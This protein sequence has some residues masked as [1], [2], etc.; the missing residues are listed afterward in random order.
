MLWGTTPAFLEKLGIDSLDDLPPLA[1]FVPGA[2]VVEALEH[3]LR[4]T[5]DEPSVPSQVDP[6]PSTNGSSSDA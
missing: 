1:G 3:S 4:I 5:D 2:D 6:E